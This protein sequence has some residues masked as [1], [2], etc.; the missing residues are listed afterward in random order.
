MKLSLLVKLT[1]HYIPEGLGLWG[2]LSLLR[3]KQS[4]YQ[5]NFTVLYYQTYWA[6]DESQVKHAE[7]SKGWL[8][9]HCNYKADAAFQSS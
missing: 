9:F 3:R 5:N 8:S 4:M 7:L 1:I 6:S 2:F